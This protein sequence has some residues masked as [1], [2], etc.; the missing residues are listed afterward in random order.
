MLSKLPGC[1][2]EPDGSF[3]WVRSGEAPWR[4]EGCLYDRDD[5]L[6]YLELRGDGPADAVRQILSLLA[7]E[8]ELA[9]QLPQQGFWLKGGDFLAG[10][11]QRAT[12]ASS[13][14]SID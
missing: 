7:P 8:E 14:A 5:R 9:V 3:A 6:V 10:L 13:S 4:L 2:F 12:A 1:Y 11:E